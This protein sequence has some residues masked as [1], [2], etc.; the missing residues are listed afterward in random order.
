MLKS[1]IPIEEAIVTLRE[2]TGN[3]QMKKILV[4]LESDVANGQPLS[5]SLTHYKDTFDPF[6]INLIQIGE[7]SGNLENNLAYLAE[8][9]KKDYEFRQKVTGASIYP[10][11]IF[12]TALVVGGG[13]AYFVLPKLVDIIAPLDIELPLSTK[14]LLWMATTMRDSGTLILAGAIGVMILL[15]L[16]YLIKAVRFLWQKLM[17][18]LPLYGEFYVNVQMTYFCRN[19]GIMLRSGLPIFEALSSLRD[20]TNNLVFR[21]YIGRLTKSVEQG[22]SLSDAMMKHNM[23]EVPMMAVKMVTV[24][25]KSG[26]LPE[27]LLYLS[28]YFE[29]E[30]DNTAKTF[31]NI[32][33]P[34]MLLIVGAMVAFVAFSIISPIYRFTGSIGK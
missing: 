21:S 25:D 19:L 9:L 26:K 23:K 31:S 17:T 8:G 6:Y 13:V 30:V 14:I 32:V 27:S 7:K 5:E 28:N 1:G 29:E 10:S 11:I 34:A 16:L 2:Q 15:W 20:A 24:G 33:E 18:K 4:R 12:V 22:V 3:R